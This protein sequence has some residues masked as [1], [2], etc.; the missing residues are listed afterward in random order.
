M[1]PW[2]VCRPSVADLNHF[3]KEQDPHLDP[4]NRALPFIYDSLYSQER[5]R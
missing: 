3:D 2:R 5:R 1:E 4:P